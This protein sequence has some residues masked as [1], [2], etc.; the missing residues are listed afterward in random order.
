MGAKTD[1]GVDGGPVVGVIGGRGGVGASTLAAALA[2]AAA[3]AML[4]DLD[5][6]G[7]GIDVLLGAERLDGARW[8]GLAL[9]GGNLD[10]EDLLA[11]LPRVGG[12]AVLAADVAHLDAD[13][14]EQVLGAAA[15][16]GPVI[17]DLPRQ[18]IAARSAALA[19]CDL[20][21]VLI[22]SDVGGL[23]AAH[24]TLAGLGEVPGAV[25]VVVRRGEVAPRRAGALLGVPVLGTLPSAGRRH[26]DPTRPPRPL[27]RVATAI[28][29]GLGPGAAAAG[30][31]IRAVGR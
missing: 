22:D 5:P 19:A 4:V 11:G 8:S 14:A 25:A 13:A 27:R 17:V 20:V 15:S 7:G 9:G 2:L 29:A 21:A 30:P 26:V 16:A 23:A 10:P 18:P 12:I 31:G 24:A 1:G 28:L 6:A 3:P